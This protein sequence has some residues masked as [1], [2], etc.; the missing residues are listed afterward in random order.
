MRVLI[1]DD[2]KAVR[3]MLRRMLADLGHDAL[4]AGTGREAL[5]LLKAGNGVEVALVDW[6]MPEMAG[7]EFIRTVRQDPSLSAMRIIVVT[8]QMDVG[9]L[10]EALEAGAQGYIV[11]P[12]T[13][14]SLLAKLNAVP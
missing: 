1:V 8:T 5:T 2:S 13:P 3:L 11:K 4:E 14:A 10:A 7:L 12:P 9:D 6:N